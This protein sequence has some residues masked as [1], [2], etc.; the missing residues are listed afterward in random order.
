MK[1]LIVYENIPESSDIY[2]VDVAVEDWQWMKLTHGNYVN[3]DMSEEED[4]A[5]Q[6]LSTLLED[7]KKYHLKEPVPTDGIAYVLLTG[8]I[9]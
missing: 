5:C 8:F 6:K 2:I 7:K 9:C 3:A 4:A 1:V